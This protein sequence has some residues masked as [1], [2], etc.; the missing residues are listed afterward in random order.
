VKPYPLEFNN[1]A[2]NNA[3][4]NLPSK[5]A[6]QPRLRPTPEMQDRLRYLLSRRDDGTLTPEEVQA[7][8]EYERIEHLNH[9]AQSGESALSGAWG[10]LATYISEA[11]RREVMERA[12]DKIFY[13][14]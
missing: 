11:L 4:P 13:E 10:G 7:L 6:K 5:A 14:N 8:D 1:A 2:S 12:G 3:S 9:F